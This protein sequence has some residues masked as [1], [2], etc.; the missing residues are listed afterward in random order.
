MTFIK[1]DASSLNKLVAGLRSIPRGAEQ[2]ATRAIN[3]TLNTTRTEITTRVRE[4]YNVK[5]SAL[6]G[7]LKITKA[8]YDHPEGYLNVAG[9]PGIPLINFRARERIS[10]ARIPS[11]RWTGTSPGKIPEPRVGVSGVINRNRGRKTWTGAFVARMRSGHVGVFRRVERSP[12]ARRPSGL[13][14]RFIREQYGPSA[15]RILTGGRYT[16]NIETLVNDTM[17]KNMRRET[18]NLL[19]KLG[20]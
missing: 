14:R 18:R 11:T 2:A 5:V 8:K 15:A 7:G 16:K 1:Y 9:P 20:R 6:K 10:P 3:R 19:R 4:D 13:G 17:R 12:A